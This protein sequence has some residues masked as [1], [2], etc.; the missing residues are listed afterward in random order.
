[1]VG[2][3]P[4]RRALADEQ[5]NRQINAALVLRL[6]AEFQGFARE[7]YD[8]LADAVLGE[9]ACAEPGVRIMLSGTWTRPERWIEATPTRRARQRL[10]PL[11]YHAVD[12][13][14]ADHFTAEFGGRQPW[15]RESIANWNY[16][17]SATP[18]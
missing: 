14:L 2:L 6:S 11:R 1:L 5:I 18:W 13:T 16:P 7:L 9:V 8:E 3:D 17:T 15:K 4:G 10:C 12:V